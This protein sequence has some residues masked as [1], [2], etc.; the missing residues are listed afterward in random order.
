MESEG[1][2]PYPQEPASNHYPKPDQF[3]PDPPI[4]FLEDPF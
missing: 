4:L 2:V 1:T 3:S